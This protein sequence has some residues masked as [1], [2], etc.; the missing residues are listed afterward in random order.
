MQVRCIALVL[1]LVASFCCQ[2]TAAE[3]GPPNI[4]FIFSDDLAYQ[5]ISAY[6]DQRK[7]LERQ[8]GSSSSRRHALRSCVVGNSIVDR[9]VQPF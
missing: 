6:G 1:S 4:L 2:L 3:K 8:Y 9:A 7:L 5:A